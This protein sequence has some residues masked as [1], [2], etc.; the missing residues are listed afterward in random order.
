MANT[1]VGKVR[2]ILVV[3]MFVISA[4]AYLDRVNI[5]IAGKAI[6]AEFHLTNLQIGYVFSAF[7]L[8]YALF[9]IPGGR[10]VDFLGPRRVLAAGVLWW[11]LFTALT[12][13]VPTGLNISLGLFVLV[14]FLLGSGESVVYPACNRTIAKWI[15]VSERGIANGII[16]AGVGFGAGVTPLLVTW[17]ILHW[18]WRW[19]F[20][21][22]A[23]IGLLTG[24]AWY[25][26]ARDDPQQHPWVSDAEKNWISQSLD[27]PAKKSH[28]KWR[29]LLSN[30]NV[31]ALSISYFTYGYSAYIFFTWF[32]LYLVDVRGVN[33]KTSAF[34]SMLPF[35]A[36]TVGSIT[37]GLISD[38]VTRRFGPR[39]GRSGIAVIGMLL[40]A[41][42]IA[43]GSHAQNIQFASLILAGG[44]GALYLS[45]SS[46]WSATAD[47]GGVYAGSVSSMMNMGNQI[48]GAITASL[49]PLIASHFGWNTSFAVAAALCVIGA[50]AWIVF[51]PNYKLVPT[52]DVALTTAAT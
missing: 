2:W 1:R 15:P 7:L 34:Y 51:D 27:A 42:F 48:G 39:L 4:V 49:T 43:L 35:I 38:F 45:Q 40:A 36:M 50:A 46:F 11:G 19:S 23:I 52:Q 28:L 21:M 24:A 14:R 3:W 13:L 22:S 30:R 8:G 18:G 10:L 41:V 32:F 20:W 9:Q 31:L 5:S 29:T 25:L 16:F 33:L 44:A 17:I 12:A 37:G 6:A 26:L 47:L